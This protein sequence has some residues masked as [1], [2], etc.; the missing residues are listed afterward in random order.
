MLNSTK[1]STV[2]FCQPGT[3]VDR[4]LESVGNLL[5]ERVLDSGTL[6]VKKFSKNRAE[7]VRFERFLWNEK[8]TTPR[9][10]NSSQ[11]MV[12]KN[13]E[14]VEHVLAIQDTT[15]FSFD[16]R[17]GELRS[18][19]VIK[20]NKAMGFF[21][22][23]VIAVDIKDTFVLGLAH[24]QFWS[25]DKDRVKKSSYERDC[26]DVTE[27]ESF[28][29]IE[30]ATNAKLCLSG[31]RL[32]TFVSDRESDIYSIFFD[33]PDKKNHVLIR[34]S[35]DRHVLSESGKKDNLSAFMARQ[36]F[37]GQRDV[38]VPARS[39]IS[40]ARQQSVMQKCG[41]KENGR[42]ERLAKLQIRY[43]KVTIL[44]PS[45]PG[46]KRYPPSVELTCV[47]VEETG[48]NDEQKERIHW[49]LLTTHQ[50][51]NESDAWFVVDMYRKR[52]T[53][54]Q[55]FRTAKKGGFQIENIDCVKREA[56][57]KLCFIGMLASVKVLQLTLCREGTIARNADVI[58]NE[59][60][61]KVLEKLN[62]TLEG[63]TIK[64]KNPHPARTVA[65]AHW[66]V[67]R[68]GGWMGYSSAGPAGPVV[69]KL[70]LDRFERYVEAFSLL[71]DVCIT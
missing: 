31:A 56:I 6:I 42:P 17:R 63:K 18:M 59:N 45:S 67:G 60:E 34:S 1:N 12:A 2:E 35:K 14:G 13:A 50:C 28:R 15:E 39:K 9:M 22:H 3:F 30:A 51:N 27:K 48:I 21:A 11:Q 57:E 38:L 70:G 19:G 43:S 7:Q 61:Q 46:L 29:W 32:V 10:L 36:P 24:C 64:Q 16:R 26:Q 20:N 47:E 23:P 44:R 37:C 58:F 69:L 4:R 55:L 40:D 62:P 66:I 54:E 8:V 5:L 25:W 49:R 68:L 65:W 53:I 33:V 41:L 52:W 71:K